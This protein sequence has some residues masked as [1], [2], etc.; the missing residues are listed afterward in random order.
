MRWFDLPVFCERQRSKAAYPQKHYQA[1]KR[2]NDVARPAFNGGEHEKREHVEKAHYPKTSQWPKQN[3][4]LAIPELPTEHEVGNNSENRPK[5][6]DPTSH[7]VYLCPA[8]GL[9][10]FCYVVGH[11]SNG[12][13][14]RLRAAGP[15]YDRNCIAEFAAFGS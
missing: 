3:T 14:Q 10:L 7:P 6:K 15:D 13:N 1:P 2:Y 8:I 5:I 12:P 9:E 11:G 4:K